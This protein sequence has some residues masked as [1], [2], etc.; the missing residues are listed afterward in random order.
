MSLPTGRIAALAL[1]VGSA[2][3]GALALWAAWRLAAWPS[4]KLGFFRD[5]VV[6][7]QG[8]R[9]MRAVWALMEAVML[10]DPGAWPHVRLTD[11]LTISFKNEAPL[12]F[13]P[14]QFGL[15]PAACRDLVIRLR[16]DSSLRARLP[17]FD[18]V[19]DLAVSPVVAGELIDPR[20]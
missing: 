14:A 11:R 5:R 16:D 7:V 2:W 4:G 9:E 8:K 3:G 15:D 12:V 17:E 10:S 13:K 20:L 1:A 6:V 19:R 18:S